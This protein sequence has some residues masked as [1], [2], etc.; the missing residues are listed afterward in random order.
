MGNGN[1]IDLAA[2]RA[3]RATRSAA[4]E[5]ARLPVSF[6]FDLACPFSYLAAERAERLLPGARW[7]PVLADTLQA[8]D[9]WSDPEL[10]ELAAGRAAELRLALV[11]PARRPRQALRA[12]RAAAFACEQGRGPAFATAA[13]RLAFCGG[14]DLS[15]PEV[16]AEAAGSSGVDLDGCLRAAADAGRDGALEA[17]GRRLLARGADRLPVVALGDVLYTGESGVDCA[18]LALRAAVAAAATPAAR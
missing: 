8:A 16:L 11:W 17:P 9:P 15:D 2:H 1:V 14:F 5:R 13:L 7:Q 4:V 18:A 10:A 12:M 3:A 6:H